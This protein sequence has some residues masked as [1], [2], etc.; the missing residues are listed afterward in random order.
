MRSEVRTHV[1]VESDVSIFLLP[2]TVIVGSALC[3]A[4]LLEL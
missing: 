3:S 1:E 2:G 4:W